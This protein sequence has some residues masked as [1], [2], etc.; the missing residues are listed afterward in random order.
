MIEGV[1]GNIIWLNSGGMTDFGFAYYWKDIPVNILSF[2]SLTF[3]LIST[4]DEILSFRRH[5][6]IC[7]WVN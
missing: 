4:E 2:G 7:T 6:I 1:N 5:L 3:E